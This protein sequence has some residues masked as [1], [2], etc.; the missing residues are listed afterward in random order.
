MVV[1]AHCMSHPAD[2]PLNETAE[3]RPIGAAPTASADASRATSESLCAKEVL[4][5]T[6]ETISEPVG[7]ELDDYLCAS[8][9]SPASC[10]GEF[11][12]SQY[13]TTCTT[14]CHC[15]SP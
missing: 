11:S 2:I 1:I 7:D 5:L 8:C 13:S 15:S 12:S 3:I 4:D 10:S 9:G 6:V 14:S